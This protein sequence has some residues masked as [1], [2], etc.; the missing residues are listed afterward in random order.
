MLGRQRRT[1]EDLSFGLDIIAATI[2]L[3]GVFWFLENFQREWELFLTT[4]TGHTFQIQ[5]VSHLSD[6][7]WLLLGLLVCVFASLRINRFYQLDLFAAWPEVVFQSVKCILIGVCLTS[8]YFY[9]FS[10]FTFNR[11]LLFG[12]AGLF[13]AYQIVKEISLRR[14]L[15]DNYYSK[16]PLEALLVT[17]SRNLAKRWHD[18]SADQQHNVR[19]KG[20][21]VDDSDCPKIPPHA[22]A[23]IIG[24]PASLQQTLSKGRYD[25][26]LLGETD[27]SSVAQEVLSSCEE[28]G[29]EVWLFADFLTP[30]LA[31]PRIDE[32]RGRPVIVFKTAGHLEGQLM[33]KRVFDL[34]IALGL[35]VLSAP[36]LIG[37]AIAVKLTSKG[38][39]FFIQQRTGFRGKPFAMLKFRTMYLD[40][41]ARLTELKE[42]NEMDGPVFKMEDDPRI[43]PIGRYLRRY[44]LDELPQLFNILKGEMSLVG[45]RPL[46]TYETEKFA[47]FQDHRRYS[48]PPGL[49][50]LWQISGRNEIRSFSEWVRLDLEYIDRWNLWLDIQILFRTIPVVITG[51]GA[52]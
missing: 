39:V 44:S 38:P 5:T 27:S 31:R 25:L 1:I 2:I 43:T 9:F 41:D 48:V 30:Q 23:L 6:Q 45:P 37:L 24:T 33:V 15:L 16:N 3:G 13:C 50:G 52:K 49:T 28:Q 40:A 8:L 51:Y 10:I 46:P 4:I 12:F 35:L 21:I 42:R 34:T 11:S 47:E 36:V 19:V 18:M 20:I 29:V 22:R 26:V 32:Y 7:G 14:Y 17:T